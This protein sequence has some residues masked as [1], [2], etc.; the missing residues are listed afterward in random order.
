M[1]M[2]TGTVTIDLTINEISPKFS[3]SAEEKF[4]SSSSLLFHGII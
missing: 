2:L 3:I 1:S 4:Y